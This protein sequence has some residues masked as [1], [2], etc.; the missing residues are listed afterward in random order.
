LKSKVFRSEPEWKMKGRARTISGAPEQNAYHPD[1][2]RRKKKGNLRGRRGKHWTN[3]FGVDS[4]RGCINYDDAGTL[5]AVDIVFAGAN[6]A[7]I[8]AVEAVRDS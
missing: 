4:A 6:T 1:R 2:K 7:N 3:T 8:V 5:R